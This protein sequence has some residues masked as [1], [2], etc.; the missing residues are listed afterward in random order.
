MYGPQYYK[1]RCLTTN[2]DSYQSVLYNISQFL[3]VFIILKSYFSCHKLCAF[4]IAQNFNLSLVV[5]WFLLLLWIM[6]CQEL[7]KFSNDMG[8]HQWFWIRLCCCFDWRC[9][10]RLFIVWGACCLVICCLFL[11][12]LLPYSDFVLFCC[13]TLN[14]CLF[15]W[16]C[17]VL[18]SSY[19]V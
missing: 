1:L 7:Y 19:L 18:A 8:H 6:L 12:A 2:T 5:S 15:C 17:F 10:I 11:F 16:L 4:S 13:Y 3:G 9:Q 14:F